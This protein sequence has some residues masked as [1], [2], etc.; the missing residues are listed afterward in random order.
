MT[1]IRAVVVTVSDRSAAGKRDDL[2][3]PVAMKAL[4]E[5]GFDTASVI[6]PDG[7]ASVEQAL[8]E[9]LNR[10]AR[11]IITSGGTGV[12]PRDHTPEGTRAVITRELPGIAEMLRAAPGKPHAYLSRGIAGV[13][14]RAVIINLPGSPKAV[15]ESMVLITPLL[16]HLLD[17]L[18]GKDH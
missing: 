8:R 13:T 18:D 2:S 1:T 12:G 9:A 15:T 7:A 11:V 14:D 6:V 16:D 4:A 3:G 10:D 5:A 17:Q